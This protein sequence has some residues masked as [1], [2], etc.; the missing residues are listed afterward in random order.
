MMTPTFISPASRQL[1]VT[2]LLMLSTMSAMTLV[3]MLAL[4]LNLVLP[5]SSANAD[6][7]TEQAA[8]SALNPDER[9]QVTDPYLEMHTG[10]GRG[11]PVFF[12]VP[13][14]QGVWI[15]LRHTDWYKVHTEEGKEG[16]VQRAQLESTLTAA[17][18]QKPFRDLLLDDYLNRKVQL[19]AAWGEFKSE[20][21]LKIW[22]S[23]RL[24]ETLSIEGTV[25]EVQGVF[26]GTDIWHIN[27]ISEPWSDQRI[28][29]FFGIGLG[30]FKNLPNQ[31]LVEA[32][33]TN[34]QLG[35]ATVGVRYYL[36]ER[37]ILR[38]DYT[39][40][41]AFVSNQRSIEYRAFTGG[42]SFFF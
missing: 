16:W 40:Y 27:I 17:G 9:L 11:Y 35:N 3:L 24:S 10:P 37:F 39:I 38:A 22:T 31:S 29:P 14:G 15:V 7:L 4:G 23:Y 32:L 1:V 36:N 33:P 28:S 19:G 20:P 25:A 5:M 2:K 42:I 6:N 12:V 8:T 34:A 18:V 41:T 26:S 21:M 13:R 30:K